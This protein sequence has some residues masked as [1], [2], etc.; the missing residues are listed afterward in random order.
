MTVQAPSSATSVEPQT[1]AAPST[2]PKETLEVP[3]DLGARLSGGPIGS[4]RAVREALTLNEVA[5]PPGA[6][7]A[8]VARLAEKQAWPA[9]YQGAVRRA[10]TEMK[11]PASGPASPAD[12]SRGAAAKRA[13][14]ASGQPLAQGLHSQLD[15]PARPTRTGPDPASQ[16]GSGTK[17]TAGGRELKPG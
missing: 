13:H 17:Q 2:P 3:P 4:A 10:T 12:P 9:Q 11:A 16:P 8:D 7:D 6:S 15:G 5:I 1:R 14:P